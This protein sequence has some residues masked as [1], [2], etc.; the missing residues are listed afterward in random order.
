LRLSRTNPSVRSSQHRFQFYDALI[1][2]AA[3][4]ADCTTLYTDHL[5]SGRVIDGRLTI[6]NPFNT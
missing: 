2:D 5:Q 1:V 3:L 6:N 4:E